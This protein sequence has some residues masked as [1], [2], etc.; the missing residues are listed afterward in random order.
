M[1]YLKLGKETCIDGVWGRVKNG[2]FYNLQQEGTNYLMREVDVTSEGGSYYAIMCEHPY[3]YLIF[4]KPHHPELKPY[5]PEHLRVLSDIK[6]GDLVWA[7]DKANDWIPV[8]YERYCN[9]TGKYVCVCAVHYEGYAIT[10]S[11]HFKAISKTCPLL[12][13][14]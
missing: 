9:L 14:T 10:D 4:W 5:I 2:Y 11:E 3:E 7:Q 1:E 13:N 8:M 6:K 12:A